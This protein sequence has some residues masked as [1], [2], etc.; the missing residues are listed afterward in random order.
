MIPIMNAP[1]VPYVKLV[2]FAKAKN[3]TDWYL[4]ALVALWDAGTSEGVDPTVLAAQCAHETGFGKFG[5]AVTPEHGNTAGIKILDPSGETA[6]DHARFAI[7]RD[8]F[9]RQ[10][11][12]AHAHHLRLYSGFPV[13]NSPDPRA[14]YISPGTQ[15]FGSAL[16]VEQ[17]GGSW[18]PSVDYGTSVARIV[19]DM[20]AFV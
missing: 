5:R 9:P 4:K 19:V 15:K 6:N 17:L 18:A 16:Y 8:G 10:G 3:A 14:K 1:T 11:A 20:Q 7:T 12:L 13:V 2:E